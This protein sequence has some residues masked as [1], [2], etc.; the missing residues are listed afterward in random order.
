MK[1]FLKK[2]EHLVN[3]IDN[4]M[5][6]PITQVLTGEVFTHDPSSHAHSYNATEEST[7]KAARPVVTAASPTREPRVADKTPVC[8][9][10]L[11][12]AGAHKK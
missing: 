3:I 7:Q 5:Q 12:P 9:P 11:R 6:Q 10:Q 1:S 4:E 8:P 2:L